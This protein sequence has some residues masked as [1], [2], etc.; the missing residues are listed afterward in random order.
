MRL[1]LRYDTEATWD[2]LPGFLATAVDVHRRHRIPATFFCT[3]GV[4][5]R[6]A[7]EFRDFAAA[8]AGDPLFDIQDHSYSHIGI[9]Y[10]AGRPVEVLRADYERSFA[11]HERVIGRRPTGVSICGVGDSGPHLRGFDGTPK[12]RAELRMLADLGVRMINTFRTDREPGSE[13][14]GYADFGLPAV[15]GFPS[16]NS[17]TAWLWKQD[18]REGTARLIAEL[19]R[20]AQRGQHACVMS[21][22]WVAWRHGYDRR[23]SHIVAI[24]DAARAAGFELATHAGCYGARELWAAA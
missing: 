20:S 7:P 14:C 23:L 22:D 13:F 2:A 11:A 4:L 8:T 3:G 24:A 19:R 18:P 9:G 15:M 6:R 16:A 12:A 21:H 10:S 5:D 17:D 1:L